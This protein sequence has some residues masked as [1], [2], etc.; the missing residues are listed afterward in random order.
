M[1][2]QEPHRRKNMEEDDTSWMTIWISS[3]LEDSETGNGKEK[4]VEI[5]PSLALLCKFNEGNKLLRFWARNDDDVI[6]SDFF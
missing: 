1:I 4:I 3:F 5:G 2:K 6:E